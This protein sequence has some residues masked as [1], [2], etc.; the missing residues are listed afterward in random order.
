MQVEFDPATVE[1][2]RLL[3][4]ENRDVADR[5]FRNDRVD[6][7]EIG[8]GHSATALYEVRLAPRAR[9]NDTIGTLRLRWKSA[10]TG[11]VE[12]AALVLRVR[13]LEPP[14]DDA[15][16]NLRRAAVAAELAEMLK[17]TFYA[18]E[19]SWRTLR[20]EA[21]LLERTSDPERQPDALRTMII[22]AGGVEQP[23]GSKKPTSATSN[24]GARAHDTLAVELSGGASKRRST[25]V[26]RALRAAVP[27]PSWPRAGPAARSRSPRR[28]RAPSP[29]V[30]ETPSSSPPPRNRAA[31]APSCAARGSVRARRGDAR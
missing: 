5:D 3:G 18:K 30:R 12:E 4:Y 21:G 2:C 10:A 9:L 13:D 11:N 1:R 15:S 17:G 14:F 22:R 25:G 23:S 20:A 28:A 16:D 19:A 24:A 31:T 8:A 26:S 27:R 7:G 29:A 6:A